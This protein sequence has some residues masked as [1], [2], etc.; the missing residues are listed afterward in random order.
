LLVG[1]KAD[2]T[3]QINQATH[4]SDVTATQNSANDLNTA[5]DQLNQAIANQQAIKQSVNYTDANNNLK[6]NY[7]NAVKSLT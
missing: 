7:S 2:L 3:Q 6:E 1:Q 5:M 4:V